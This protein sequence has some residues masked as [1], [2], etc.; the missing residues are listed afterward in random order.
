RCPGIEL[1]EALLEKSVTCDQPC[2]VF[3]YGGAPGVAE[4]AAQ[5]WQQRIPGLVVVGT[6]HGYHDP[7]AA[8]TIQQQLKDTQPGMILVGLG[9]P[10]QEHWIAQ[11]RQLCPQAIWIGVG[12]SFD[13]WA[14]R[15]LRAPAWLK[16]NH[17]EWVYRLYKEPWRW[18]RML[19][20]PRFAWRAL[21]E[22]FA[23]K[24]MSRHQLS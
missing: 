5:I 4:V 12:G 18:R 20:L 24:F 22:S 15:K 9:V 19:A 14:G 17:L 13:I 16:D 23:K 2:P 11:H 21:V 1:A 7:D 6:Q 3:F 10:R 8:S